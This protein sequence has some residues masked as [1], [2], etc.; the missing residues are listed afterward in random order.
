MV[1]CDFQ[2]RA[3]GKGCSDL[4][5]ILRVMP[6]AKEHSVLCYLGERVRTTNRVACW[7]NHASWKGTHWH[8]IS[9][10]P[11]GCFRFPLDSTRPPKQSCKSTSIKTVSACLTASPNVKKVIQLS[12]ARYKSAEGF[13]AKSDGWEGSKRICG[14]LGSS[15]TKCHILQGF[16]AENKA[17]RCGD[18][19]TIFPFG[20][21]ERRGW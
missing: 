16:L 15:W 6:K 14:V 20:E 7:D 8:P 3:P 18:V 2:H 12:G 9:D 5:P 21:S 19:P 11:W 10:L 4:L 1:R 13:L 17:R